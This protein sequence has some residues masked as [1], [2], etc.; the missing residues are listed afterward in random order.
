MLIATKPAAP[1]TSTRAMG[2]TTGD[3]PSG[4][5]DDGVGVDL[6][7]RAVADQLRDADERAGRILALRP[8][9]RARLVDVAQRGGIDL[10]GVDAHAHDVVH[11]A[12]LALQHVADVFEELLGLLPHRPAERAVGPDAELAGDEEHDA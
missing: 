8:E 1:V 12:A 3:G 6:D 9:L 2:A 11:R 7:E 4:G 10:C 5:R